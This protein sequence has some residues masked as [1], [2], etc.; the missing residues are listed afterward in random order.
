MKESLLLRLDEIS[1]RYEE[2]GVLL[3]D[4][5]VISDQ[6]KFRDFS[7]EYSDLEPVVNASRS[8]SKQRKISRKQKL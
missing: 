1:E 5:S 3:S 8:I 6:N 2:L 7:K 4:P